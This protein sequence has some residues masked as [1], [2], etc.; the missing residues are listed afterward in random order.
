MRR[1]IGLLLFVAL[2][3]PPAIDT[4]SLGQD[5][6]DPNSS[7]P[8][9]FS[10]EKIEEQLEGPVD[11]ETIVATSGWINSTGVVDWLG[12]LA[13]VAL[14]PFF[15]VTCLSGLAL[16]GPDWMA[17]NAVLNASGPLQSGWLFAIFLLLTILTSLPRLTKVSKPFAQAVDRLETYSVIVILL[18]IKVATSMESSGVEQV[19]MV[20]LGIVSFT[21]DTLLAIAMVDQYPGDQ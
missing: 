10:V 3:S 11:V 2:V 16:W 13:P 12:P 5:T 21:V 20:Q 7:A 6:A 4:S 8:D 19:A 9:A 1:I 15:G 14:S 17:D 18:A